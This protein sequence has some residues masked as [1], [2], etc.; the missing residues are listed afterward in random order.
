MSRPLPADRQAI[1]ARL[2][3]HAVLPALEDLAALSPETRQLA[4]GWKFSLRLALLGG[5]SATLISPG[6]GRLLVT[7][8]S[9]A[10]ALLVLQ[11]LTANQ[12]N[13]TFLNQGALPPLPTGGFWRILGVQTFVKL[14]KQLDRVLQ[15]T[16]AALAD[17]PFRLLHLRLLFRVLIGAVPIVAETDAVSRHTLSHTPP[18]T[19]ELRVPALGLVGHMRWAHGRLTSALGPAPADAAPDA[20][21]TFVDL[22]TADDALLGR[23]DPNAAV[24]LGRVDVR[25]L[26]PLAD[27]MSVVMDRVEGYIKPPGAPAVPAM[28]FSGAAG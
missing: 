19:V 12:L 6:D 10:P 16:P 25:G 13:R 21:I 14:T 20:V 17:E 9:T 26:I 15:A 11:F 8:G 18:G 28:A 1:L 3:L 5:P 24:G 22:P 2:H 4:A 27:G 23:L 7:P